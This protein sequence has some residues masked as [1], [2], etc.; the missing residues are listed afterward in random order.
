VINEIV[1]NNAGAAPPVEQLLSY[2]VDYL[3]TE[4]SISDLLTEQ[5]ITAALGNTINAYLT[6]T[7]AGAIGWV[8]LDSV[9][10]TSLDSYLTRLE[11]KLIKT[12]SISDPISNR[13]LAIAIGRNDLA[14]WETQLANPSSDWTPFF[15]GNIA[16]DT[17]TLPYWV[18]AA[19]RG[20][21]VGFNQMMACDTPGTMNHLLS[22]LGGSIVLAA[23]RVLYGWE[24]KKVPFRR[25]VST[26]SSNEPPSIPY[27]IVCD[28]GDFNDDLDFS[29][30]DEADISANVMASSTGACCM[31]VPCG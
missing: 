4:Y 12:K 10:P 18:G 29:S 22:A 28:N 23:G 8:G 9:P 17:S 2:V 31:A 13:M 21:A 26:G 25:P 5:A 11:Q 7:S 27:Y 6:G 14:Y 16:I 19:M 15:N 30:Q 24:P 3:K 1:A 20:S